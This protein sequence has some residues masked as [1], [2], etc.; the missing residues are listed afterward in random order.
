MGRLFRQYYP[1][2]HSC[3][4]DNTDTESTVSRA[5][6]LLLLILQMLTLFMKLNSFQKCMNDIYI[7]QTHTKSMML[8]YT[9]SLFPEKLKQVRPTFRLKP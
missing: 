4:D 7:L 5:E 9:V 6:G 1:N 3:C 2:S 8:K